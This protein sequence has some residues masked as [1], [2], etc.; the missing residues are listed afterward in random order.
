MVDVLAGPLPARVN[1]LD[2]SIRKDGNPTFP[3]RHSPRSLSKAKLAAIPGQRSL[4]VVDQE[5]H[6]RGRRLGRRCTWTEWCDQ[7]E[8]EKVLD[9]REFNSSDVVQLMPDNL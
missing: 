8:A 4:D 5:R 9:L 6:G 2:S 3:A 1:A 7:V